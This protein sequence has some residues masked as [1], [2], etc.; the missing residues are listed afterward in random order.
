[1]SGDPDKDWVNSLTPEQVRRELDA[2]NIDTKS[3]VK[4]VL[5]MVR[6][7]KEKHAAKLRERN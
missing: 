1:M 7:A 2:R 5:N 3:A 4:H 6:D